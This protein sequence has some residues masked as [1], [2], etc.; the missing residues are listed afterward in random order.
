[1]T[2]K[3]RRATADAARG[4]RRFGT[5]GHIVAV[6]PLAERASGLWT[7]RERVTW[8]VPYRGGGTSARRDYRR[9]ALRMCA[10][11]LAAHYDSADGF[12]LEDAEPDCTKRE[13]RAFRRALRDVIRGLYRKAGIEWVHAD[14]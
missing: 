1:M 9:E 13:A 7:A 8:P 5:R 3:K 11:D 4:P 12:H 2:A 6:I 10:R 14:D